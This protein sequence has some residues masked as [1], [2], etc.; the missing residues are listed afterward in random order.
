MAGELFDVSRVPLSMVNEAGG[1]IFVSGH[2][3]IDASGRLLSDGSIE[4]QADLVLRNINAALQ[5]HGSCMEDVVKVNVF[6]ARAERDFPAMNQVYARHFA[7]SPRPARSTM[8]V[9]LAVDVLIE[10]EAIAVRG[11]AANVT[12]DREARGT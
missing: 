11:H 1:L 7:F 12:P 10:I 5:T 4:D 8:G 9:E 3:P 2:V 6:L